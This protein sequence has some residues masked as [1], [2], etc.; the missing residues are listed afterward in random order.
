[1]KVLI[2]QPWISY[3]GA[4]TI[5]LLESIGLEKLGI[6]TSVACL[7]VDKARM[8]PE[9]HNINYILPPKMLSKLFYSSRILFYILGFPVLSILILKNMHSFDIL[10]PHNLPSHWICAFFRLVKQK[11][12]I[13]TVHGITAKTTSTS[14]VI[15]KILWSFIK[16]LDYWAT[17]RMDAIISE[18]EKVKKEVIKMYGRDS[19]VIYPAISQNDF[20]ISRNNNGIKQK[21]GLN[22]KDFLLLHTSYL[23]PAKNVELSIMTLKKVLKTIPNAKLMIAGEGPNENYLKNLV[24]KNG[25]EGKVIFTGHIIPNKI[26]DFYKICD[27]VLVPYFETEGCSSVPFEALLVGRPSIVAK[28]SGADEIIGRENLGLVS[29]PVNTAFTKAVLSFIRNRNKWENKLKKNKGFIAKNLSAEAYAKN[30]LSKV[31]NKKKS[32]V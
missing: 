30:F 19:V 28:N 11:T 26:A 14:T 2:I 12:T 21:Y 32:V 23:H 4:E 6:K 25:L 10:N 20:K 31:I 8:S 7:Y 13:W 18:S 17:R 15:Q 16:P 27:L 29:E 1:M 22:N 9:F 5:S 3:R 24:K